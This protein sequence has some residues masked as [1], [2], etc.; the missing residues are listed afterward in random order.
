MYQRLIVS[1]DF[2]GNK[3]PKTFPIDCD[4]QRFIEAIKRIYRNDK[5]I[6][7]F[8]DVTVFLR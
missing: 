1:C 3:G 6:K 8:R 7:A 2:Q 4:N 5:R